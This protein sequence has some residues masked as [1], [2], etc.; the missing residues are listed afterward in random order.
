MAPGHCRRW[1]TLCLCRT[2]H[3]HGNA[4]RYWMVDLFDLC[5]GG[6]R[7]AWTRPFFELLLEGIL[8]MQKI[9]S[10]QME[11]IPCIACF[12][13]A[14]HSR[15]CR[16]AP[17]VYWPTCAWQCWCTLGWIFNRF[18]LFIV[19]FPCFVFEQATRTM[20]QFVGCFNVFFCFSSCDVDFLKSAVSRWGT[21]HG[22][23]AEMTGIYKR[24]QFNFQFT[25]EHGRL[26]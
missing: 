2:G 12:I 5:A 10:K 6:E 13:I 23:H 17:W 16:W 9:Q 7:S 19:F 21:S 26:K 3:G 8:E 15:S 14:P 22:E 25:E 18:F 20:K 1:A 4:V 24:E 11:Q